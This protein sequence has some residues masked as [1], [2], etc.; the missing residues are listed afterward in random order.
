MA[1]QG[2]T[3][4]I[5]AVDGASTVVK[6]LDTNLN[7]GRKNLKDLNTESKSFSDFMTKVGK[8]PS[9]GNLTKA[10]GELTT[11]VLGAASSIAKLALG[12][13]GLGTIASVG[14][15]LAAS[16]QFSNFTRAINTNSRAMGVAPKE[17]E[18]FEQVAERAGISADA[19]ASSMLNMSKTFREANINGGPA[20]QMLMAL[21]WSME[22]IA[23]AAKDPIAA[24]PKLIESLNKLPDGPMKMKIIADSGMGEQLL[25]LLNKG[26][27]SYNENWQD[28]QKTLTAT[29]E[30]I[31]K[32]EAEAEAIT[33]LE[34]RAR[35]LKNTFLAGLAPSITHLATALT[36]E[37]ATSMDPTVH[38]FDEWMQ[39]NQGIID[40]NID[41]VV[42]TIFTEV[43]E[44]WPKV[45]AVAQSLGGW[46]TCLEGLATFMAARFAIQIL[47]PFI[48]VGFYA[49]K[50]LGIM[51]DLSGIKFTGGM[52]ALGWL[53]AAYL[54][55]T[56]LPPLLNKASH[57]LAGSAA[58]DS[59]EYKAAHPDE[60]ISGAQGLQGSTAGGK[61]TSATTSQGP[62]GGRGGSVSSG[63]HSESKYGNGYKFSAEDGDIS[64]KY[65]SGGRGVGTISS[66]EG[67]KGGVSYGAHQLASKT[68]TMQTFIDSAENKQFADAFKG[69]T[70]GTAKFNEAYKKVV[71]EH[72]D[73]FNKAQSNF[74]GR[75]HYQPVADYAQSVG[76]DTSNPAIRKALYSQSVQHG[77]KGNK[78][79]LDNAK[80]SGVDMKDS[81]AVIKSIYKS[82]GDYAGQFAS[83]SATKDRYARESKDALSANAQVAALK[84]VAPLG[85]AQS[86]NNTNTNVVVEFKNAPP[87]MKTVTSS[88]GTSNVQVK[89]ASP[90]V[91]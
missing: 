60:K 24:M 89:T 70:P 43:K 58:K 88:K 15:I 76:F 29:P 55:A 17:L 57:L 64:E 61:D 68:G 48:Q 28:V 86:T 13:T 7:S 44:L 90:F 74:I 49:A 79:I 80:A 20:R 30:N 32:M 51:K 8:S 82:R 14:G 33:K 40:Q 35:E 4:S 18:A 77:F 54:V 6:K 21:K 27:K 63:H 16:N 81:D 46:T 26:V 19:A 38:S 78:T 59:P 62:R 3:I 91:G 5:K 65:E 34:Q 69:L 85:A 36:N 50:T 53:G 47:T 75:T 41:T 73:E 9:F 37:L 71:S 22:D 87:G 67:D 1:D 11:G 72:G 2:Y 25:P 31:A 45:N 12:L 23:K 39:K 42:H 10:S 56:E 66:G 52:G 83:S 84:P